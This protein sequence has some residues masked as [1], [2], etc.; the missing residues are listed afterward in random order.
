[1]YNGGKITIAIII[2]I[3]IFTSPI[4]TNWLNPQKAH[5]PEIVLPKDYKECIAETDYM[6]AYHMDLLNEWRDLVVR[7]NI[8][9]LQKDGKPFLINGKKAEMSL[10]KT[11]L[12][13]HNDKQNFCDQCHNYLDVSPYCW[14]CHVDKFNPLDV[15][16]CPKRIKLEVNVEQNQEAKQ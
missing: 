7:K 8:R 2:F 1:M 11:C 6:K 16:Q 4:W 14:D 9:Y 5:K 15:E 10:T 13:C 12:N 3:I